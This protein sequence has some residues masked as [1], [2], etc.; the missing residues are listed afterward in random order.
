MTYDSKSVANPT[1]APTQDRGEGPSVAERNIE[2]IIQG[3]QPTD[4]SASSLKRGGKHIKQE[5]ATA[6]EEVQQVHDIVVNPDPSTEDMP[7]P[8]TAAESELEAMLECDLSPYMDPP[9]QPT[10]T[11]PPDI[12]RTMPPVRILDRD[13]QPRADAPSPEEYTE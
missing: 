3:F 5:G 8:D 9:P 10:L 12:F 7:M 6:A 13:G 4:Q 11:T 1:P 2:V